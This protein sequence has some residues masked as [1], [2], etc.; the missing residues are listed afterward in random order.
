M[1][2]YQ[3]HLAHVAII[4][5]VL[6]VWMDGLDSIRFGKLIF[7]K[8]NKIGAT[9]CQILRLKCT[10]FDFCWI[11]PPDPAGGAYSI[12]RLHTAVFKGSTSKG[13]GGRER[14]ERKRKGKRNRRVGREGKG[15]GR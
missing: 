8:T 6:K 14:G 2:H 9:R 4:R 1:S 5:S 10:K 11:P 12:P 7:G 3:F 13:G 15:K